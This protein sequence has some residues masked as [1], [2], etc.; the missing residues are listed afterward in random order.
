MSMEINENLGIFIVCFKNG[1][2]MVYT[3]PKCKLINSFLLLIGNG[4]DRDMLISKTKLMGLEND[5]LFLGL[6]NDAYRLYQAMD[7]FALPSLH[8]GFPLTLIEAQTSKL[9]CVISSGVNRLTKLN[10]NVEFLSLDLKPAEWAKTIIRISAYCRCEI[11][12]SKV[13]KEYDS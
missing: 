10:D 3:L 7:C 13:I 2:C 8:E 11:D 5:V 4:N 1:Y 9:P 6:R 12:N